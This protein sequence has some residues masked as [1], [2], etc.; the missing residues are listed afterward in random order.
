MLLK[1]T[2]KPYKSMI[3]KEVVDSYGEKF[4]GEQVLSHLFG[5]CDGWI[6]S[7][8]KIY[9]YEKT[10]KTTLNRVNALWVY[11]F[12]ATLIAIPK[13]IFTGHTGVEDNT[14]MHKV[15]CWLLGEL[16]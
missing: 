6:N 3:R 1:K 10:K 15:L 11:P 5:D 13:W 12:Y 16:H 2:K 9:R 4:T 8:Y 14:K 7:D